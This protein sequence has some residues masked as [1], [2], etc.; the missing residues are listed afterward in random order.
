MN[1]KRLKILYLEDDQLDIE[2]AKSILDDGGLAYDMIEV[3][4][5][6]GFVQIIKECPP[7]IIL[8]DYHLPSFD[9]IAALEI[10]RRLVPEIP[11]IFVSGVLGEELAIETLKKGATDYVLKINL[12]RLVPSIK[13]ALKE[14][15]ERLR[16]NDI[17]E[18]L[19]ISKKRYADLYDNAP[20]IYLSVTKDARILLINRFGAESLGYKKH[21]LEGGFLWRI[22]SCP[23]I[24]GLKANLALA[25]QNKPLNIIENPSFICKDGTIIRAHYR[26][27]LSNSNK[28]CSLYE[29]RVIGRDITDH[30]R[31]RKEKKQIELNLREAEKMKAISDLAGG[32]AHRFNNALVGITGNIDLLKMDFPDNKA[33][34]IYSRRMMN[35]AKQMV[36]LT[37]SLLAYSQGGKYNAM[38]LS[39]HKIVMDTF[40]IM[41]HKIPSAVKLVI[42]VPDSLPDIEADFT[43]MQMVFSALIE[44]SLEAMSGKGK[45]QV[46]GVEKKILPPQSKR[47]GLKQGKC[48]LLEV[49]DNGRGM[50]KDTQERIFEPFYT[51]YHQ[52]RG[53][54]MA[55][56]YGIIRNHNGWIGVES[57][58]GLGTEIKLLM[59]VKEKIFEKKQAL[60]KVK[61][62]REKTVI[63]IEDEEMV[64]KVCKAMLLKLG[65]QVL[66]AENGSQAINIARTYEQDIDLALLDI[67]LPDIGGKEV[68]PI[69]KEARPDL[70]VIVC[71]GYSVEGPAQDLLDAGAE[72]LIK[73]P[74]GFKELIAVINELKL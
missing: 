43:Q 67:G 56:V 18:A 74:F 57:K 27:H 12:K 40:A 32:I 44:N 66:C 17:K 20:D 55:A 30:V 21:E 24:Q 35:A 59:P 65:Y 49:K 10:A 5:E 29:L 52:G 23:D 42:D 31:L 36:H 70:K 8:A 9:G 14:V 69:I 13:R 54:G 22:L 71:S 64:M 3:E 51:T 58:P 6:S 16:K 2:L 47:L 1:D 34:D 68:F 50:N 26:Y 38:P 28:G 33:I 73:K 63:L 4:D 61:E 72:A 39:P 11:F 46:K 41:E 15:R 48:I 62:G 19:I 60:P 37:N 53:L 45:I 25:F 7:D